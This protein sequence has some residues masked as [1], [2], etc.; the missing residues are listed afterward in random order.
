LVHDAAHE[1]QDFGGL[2]EEHEIGVLV[3][4]HDCF[5]KGEPFTDAG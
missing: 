2:K 3:D 1:L 4:V 5:V